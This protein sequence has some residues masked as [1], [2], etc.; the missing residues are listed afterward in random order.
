MLKNARESLVLMSLLKANIIKILH[1]ISV[2]AVILA[3]ILFV[4][5]GV[6]GV[7]EDE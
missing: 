6:L 5:I 1:V 2:T 4:R 3:S 7:Q